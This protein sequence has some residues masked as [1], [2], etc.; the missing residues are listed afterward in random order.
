MSIEA[1][2]EGKGQRRKKMKEEIESLFYRSYVGYT[3]VGCT[4]LEHHEAVFGKILGIT[5]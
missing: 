4:T 3:I 5:G 1:G 2:N